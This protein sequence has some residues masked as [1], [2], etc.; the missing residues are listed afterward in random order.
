MR[1]IFI[2]STLA[3]FVCNS[4]ASEHY[5]F[6][7]LP[8]TNKPIPL[9]V[10]NSDASNL[11]NLNFATQYRD[12]HITNIQLRAMTAITVILNKDK[13]GISIILDAN[14]E[15]TTEVTTE[16]TGTSTVAHNKN[17]YSLILK[18]K[19]KRKTA[20]YHYNGKWYV[21]GD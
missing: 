6:S 21:L 3:S 11:D 13:I 1:I 16:F 4:Y 14:G 19:D 5:P 17:G 2:L 9:K 18:D 15:Y 20:I 7:E 10:I 8:K 12:F